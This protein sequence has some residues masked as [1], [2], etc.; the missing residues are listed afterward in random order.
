MTTDPLH[1][2][3]PP[4]GDDPPS[5]GGRPPA[6]LLAGELRAALGDIQRRIGV[7][8]DVQREIAGTVGLLG[9]AEVQ[10]DEVRRK[11]LA[12]IEP[13]ATRE[14]A[15]IEA[16]GRLEAERAAKDSAAASERAAFFY[17]LLGAIGALTK[18]ENLRTLAIIIGFLLLAF[19]PDLAGTLAGL[20]ARVLG[21]PV[22]IAAP[23]APVTAPADEPH[24]AP[25]GAP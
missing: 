8:E 14:K 15:R 24:P 25:M 23:T 11:T 6:P 20:Y 13:L 4:S 19:R 17:R 5:R 22:P 9:Q 3:P 12:A 7:L 16:E 18:A 10:A 2:A 21:A 1:A